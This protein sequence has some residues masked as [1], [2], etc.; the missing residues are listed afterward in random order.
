MQQLAGL[1]KRISNNALFY[2]GTDVLTMHNAGSTY[3]ETGR[4]RGHAG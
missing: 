2:G 1:M 4:D 3:A